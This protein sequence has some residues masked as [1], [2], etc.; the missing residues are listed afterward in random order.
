M[1][2]NSKIN[3]LVATEVGNLFNDH[4]RILG[5]KFSKAKAQ[6]T[7]KKGPIQQLI[8]LSSPGT[9]LYYEETTATLFLRFSVNAYIDVPGYQEW[10]TQYTGDGCYV[11][12]PQRT[13]RSEVAISFD[14]L[15]PDDFLSFSR[16]AS[17]REQLIQRTDYAASGIADRSAQDFIPTADLLTT[18]INLLME[19]VGKY[20]TI[21]DI[22]DQITDP[23]PKHL[24]LLLFGGYIEKAI[25]LFETNYQRYINSIQQTQTTDPSAANV[26]KVEL[27]ALVMLAQQLLN[28]TYENP[29]RRR[30]KISEPK[31]ELFELAPGLTYQ[32]ALRF[33]T[34]GFTIDAFHVNAT[35]EVM[36]FS[37]KKTIY[38]FDASGRLVFEK[39]ILPAPGF[40][41]PFGPKS[42]SIE[43]T[44]AFFIN[45]HI[46][47]KDNNHLELPLPDMGKPGKHLHKCDVTDL[48]YSA[49]HQQYYVLFNNWFLIY[50]DKGVLEKQL[51]VEDNMHNSIVTD[52]QW[53]VTRQQHTLNT[54]LDFDG[55]VVAE[56]DFTDG[57]HYYAFSPAKDRL[58]CFF[59][60]AKSQYYDLTTGRKEVLWAHP[61]YIKGYKEIMYNDTNHNFGLTIAAFSPDGQY[62]AGGGDHGKYVAWKLPGLERVELIPMQEVIDLFK[63]ETSIAVNMAT[64]DAQTLSSAKT[65]LVELEGHTFLK[66]R[67]NDV[68]RI[69]FLDNGDYFLLVLDTGIT[70]IWDRHLK[71]IGYA[72]DMSIHAHADRF[73]SIIKENEYT[74]YTRV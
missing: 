49:A 46:I 38:K 63:P 40:C 16:H 29:F 64:G 24:G 69:L 50:N 30:I 54:I 74:V 41:P 34:T 1:I 51:A 21:P 67:S 9:N 68:N 7:R 23:A 3:A 6:F 57:N 39:T 43:A 55:Q 5:F 28:I 35:G 53:I 15:K 72:R 19:E 56:Y 2:K 48:V 25:P 52:K 12:Y 73:I 33:D 27:A 42:G 4:L 8:V 37:A 10:Y 32:E 70:M 71:N 22:V 60:T 31:Q 66:N 20:T 61:T 47:D 36:I 13:F 44:G 59:Y 26:L 17:P 11:R 45:N 58:L 62:I 65:S 18:G 14:Q